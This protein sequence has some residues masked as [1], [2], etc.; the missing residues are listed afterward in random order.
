M[1]TRALTMLE[2]MLALGI[3]LTGLVG[4]LSLFQAGLVHASRSQ[5]QLQL[6]Y[7]G[8]ELM[9][10][11]LAQLRDSAAFQQ[12]TPGTG[13]WQL[14]PGGVE[15]RWVVTQQA[16]YSPGQALEGAYP[17]AN[18]KILRKSAL[19]LQLDLRQGNTQLQLLTSACEPMRQWSTTSPLTLSSSG[20]N[21][22]G[23]DQLMDFNCSCTGSDGRP[24][25]DL[26]VSWSVV[27]V[28][29]VGTLESVARDGRTARF[30]NRT[31]RK[32]GAVRYTGGACYVVAQARYAGQ[33]RE[34]RSPLITLVGP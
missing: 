16:L 25:E 28:T 13:P 26:M 11:E 19:R 29:G 9:Q 1:P 10:Q 14:T 20:A 5:R 3:L 18:Q 12:L 24:L 21:P 17:L 6:A 8:R 2:T 27:P 23:K 34:A 31:R 30:R 33:I 22:L 32:N 4:I 15:Y 7:T